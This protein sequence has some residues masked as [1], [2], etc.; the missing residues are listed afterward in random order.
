MWRFASDVH[1]GC[2][3]AF[4]LIHLLLFLVCL[5]LLVYLPCLI[6]SGTLQRGALL[7]YFPSPLSCVRARA[8]QQ[9]PHAFILI[10][11]NAA[12]LLL[13]PVGFLLGEE[14]ICQEVLFFISERS[15]AMRDCENHSRRGAR[16]S[17]KLWGNSGAIASLT[18][19]RIP[20]VAQT[21]FFKSF[22]HV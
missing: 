6:L 10:C 8:C 19:V 18:A 16:C 15:D 13:E 22:M 7:A 3:S 11:T 20:K 21:D 4:K 2:R 5:H 12:A 9:K 17:L 1:V 14:L